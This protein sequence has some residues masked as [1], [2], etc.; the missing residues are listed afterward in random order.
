MLSFDSLE[1]EGVYSEKFS[2]YVSNF[3]AVN[4]LYVKHLESVGELL[5]TKKSY[6]EII[7]EMNALKMEKPAIPVPLE[8]EKVDS[9]EEIVKATADYETLHSACDA[10]KK[11]IEEKRDLVAKMRTVLKIRRNFFNPQEQMNEAEKIVYTL[12]KE[13]QT[14]SLELVSL[15]KK[16][17]QLRT[18]I[19]NNEMKIYQY[20]K[21]NIKVLATFLKIKEGDSYSD[22]T[23]VSTIEKMTSVPLEVIFKKEI[24]RADPTQNGYESYNYDSYECWENPV[25]LSKEISIK[26][27]P[28]SPFNNPS[29]PYLVKTHSLR[30]MAEIKESCLKEFTIN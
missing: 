28:I 14:K 9:I 21:D 25:D 23:L 2:N 12:E 20:T 5:N 27:A 4:D 10:L 29:K 11:E 24:E 30:E 3:S 13:M 1:T 8:D 16:R 15:E 6:S 22:K 19:S 18:K 17:T 7:A 26:P